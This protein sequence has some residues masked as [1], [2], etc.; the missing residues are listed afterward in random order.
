MKLLAISLPRHDASVAYFDGKNL[1]YVKLERLRES[2]R[3]AFWDHKTDLIDLYAWKYEIKNIFDID[4]NDV[5]EII[6]D[7][8][9]DT[10]YKIFPKELK[11]VILGKY[12][13]C[14]ISED[15]NIFNNVIDNK[16]IYYISHHYA[17]AL[18]TWMLH[19]EPD[20][21]ITIDGEGDQRT[22]SVYRTDKLVDFGK[23]KDGSIGGN[24]VKLAAA[25]EIKGEFN[26][27]A[28]KLMSLISYGNINF[29]YL[30]ILKKFSY[31]D[32]DKI[33]DKRNW[34]NFI[35]DEL[36]AHHNVLDWATTIHHYMGD[37]L[38]EM[39]K[40]YA[41]KNDIISY[42]GGV[43]Q[44]IVWNTRLKEEF[45]NLII[46][47]H[48]GDEGLSLGAIELLRRK[49]NLPEFNIKK[50][51]YIQN[52]IAPSKQANAGLFKYVAEL[53]SQ[54][55]IILWYQDNGEVGPRAL[56][57]RSILMDPRLVDGKKR[58]N[59]IKNRENFRPFGASVL[60]EHQTNI[61]TAKWQD[62]FMLYTSNLTDDTLHSIKHVDGTCRLQTLDKDNPSSL[63][64]LLES[65]YDIT[66]CPCLLNTSLNISGKPIAGYPEVA[67]KMLNDSTAIDYAV[68]GDKIYKRSNL[69]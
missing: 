47:P 33:F 29:D 3:F 15:A 17:H 41:D 9:L 62:D 12:N 13:Y 40:Q 36:L 20:V 21:C 57:N 32:I 46:A 25:L 26:D 53:L 27:L 42:T 67:L 66:D 43:A 35:G 28:G 48:S 68:I 37:V 11:D 4:I 60:A 24:M 5:D 64:K 54:G 44:N 52:D 34:I 63:R 23:I 14:K 61:S 45:P 7:Y 19:P 38:I 18:S 49:N 2:K 39:F 1:H 31:K 65:F 22:W 51:P 50:F 55:N 30:N 56:G 58:I 59:Q 8:H 16:N 69:R 10:A 6:F